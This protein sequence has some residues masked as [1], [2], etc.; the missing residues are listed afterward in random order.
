[1]NFLE[2]LKSWWEDVGYSY[3]KYNALLVL[4][5]FCLGLLLTLLEFMGIIPKYMNIREVIS[6]TLYLY[7]VFLVADLVNFA[8]KDSTN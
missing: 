2:Y 1:M 8:T 6:M 7:G 4:Y 3:G 5:I